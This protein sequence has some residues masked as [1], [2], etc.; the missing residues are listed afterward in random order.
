M[1]SSIH[2]LLPMLVCIRL[3]PKIAS[4]PPD[5]VPT[6]QPMQHTSVVEHYCTDH[7]I[8]VLVRLRMTYGDF[9]LGA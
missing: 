8:S 7:A 5:S 6:N 4:S 2:V 3:Q 9:V 1:G